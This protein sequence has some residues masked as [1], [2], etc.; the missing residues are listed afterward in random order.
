MIETDCIEKFDAVVDLHVADKVFR[1]WITEFEVILVDKVGCDGEEDVDSICSEKL[2]DEVLVDR[3]MR[4]EK[5]ATLHKEC[6]TITTLGL[7]IGSQEEQIVGKDN[8]LWAC[9]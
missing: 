2:H 7:D 8:C 4:K 1:V 5:D 9:G 6:K 3:E